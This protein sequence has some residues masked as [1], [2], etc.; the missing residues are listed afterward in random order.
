[1]VRLISKSLNSPV[2]FPDSPEMHRPPPSLQGTTKGESGS[3]RIQVRRLGRESGAGKEAL[4]QLVVTIVDAINSGALDP[5]KKFRNSKG[6]EVEAQHYILEEYSNEE[7]RKLSHERTALGKKT[8]ASK[9][10]QIIKAA[11]QKAPDGQ[12]EFN[13]RGAIAR[14]MEARNALLQQNSKAKLKPGVRYV[15]VYRSHAVEE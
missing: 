1:M 6:E 7:G 11:K 3:S 4:P 14:A 10:Q 5:K 13:F 8:A 12:P 15:C 9:I 2:C